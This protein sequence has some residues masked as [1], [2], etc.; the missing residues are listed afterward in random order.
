MKCK[1]TI[2][3]L[4]FNRSKKLHKLLNSIYLENENKFYK[5]IVLDNFS[6]DNTT[7]IIDKLKPKIKNLEYIKHKKNIGFREN[8]L[9]AFSICKTNYLWIFS[10]DDEI[11]R[12][13][14]KLIKNFILNNKNFSAI[15]LG[16]AYSSKD[17][18]ILKTNPK[19]IKNNRLFN[20]QIDFPQMGEISK[21]IFNFKEI[22]TFKVSNNYRCFPQLF[23]FQNL[24]KLKLPWLYLKEKIILRKKNI[25]TNDSGNPYTPNETK[26]RLDREVEEYIFCLNNIK[27]ILYSRDYKILINVLFKKNLR[28]W[29]VES[30][31]NG[32]KILINNYYFKILWKNL[33]IYNKLVFILIKYFPLFFFK[34]IVFLKREKIQKNF[35][36]KIKFLLIGIFNT[37]VNYSFSIITYYLFYQNF[38]FIFYNIVNILFG[39]T[40]SFS[41]FKFFLFKTSKYDFLKE[42]LK[43]YLVYGFKI[44]MG[45]CLLFLFLEFLK[46]NIFISQALVIIIT[47]LFTYKGHKNYTFKK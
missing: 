43:S 16:T 28:S 41:M 21:N 26:I 12:G 7:D 17:N 37:I 4:T 46:F 39:V 20:V 44:L 35:D 13:A 15:S 19:N 45:F 3:I 42:Y 25:S 32:N 22:K 47:T 14:L 36:F 8:Y 29:L 34:K 2:C 33:Y 31:I 27:K 40:F 30:K 18:L 9:Y 6:S 11:S 5:I 1:V 10:D 23:F 24:L 38:G